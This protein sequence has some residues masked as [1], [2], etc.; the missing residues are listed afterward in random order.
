MKCFYVLSL[1]N[2]EVFSELG[3]RILEGIYE[4]RSWTSGQVSL[5]DVYEADLDSE[6]FRQGVL[7]SIV[8]QLSMLDPIRYEGICRLQDASW[9]G[10]SSLWRISE[11]LGLIFIMVISSQDTFPLRG[12]SVLD[13]VVDWSERF[14]QSGGELVASDILIVLHVLA[15]VG[16]LQLLNDDVLSKVELMLNRGI[17]G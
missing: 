17:R 13:F 11:Y 6:D 4:R 7:S 8:R 15:P 5:C 10:L 3:V 12:K 9:G 16:Q 1:N 2:G 14:A